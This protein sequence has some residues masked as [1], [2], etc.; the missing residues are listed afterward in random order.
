M[1]PPRAI[2]LPAPPRRPI[3]GCSARRWHRTVKPCLAENNMAIELGHQKKAWS[4]LIVSTLP[5]T[6]CF[7]VG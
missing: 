2:V 3:G 5:F 7:M 1:A 4:V 6:V